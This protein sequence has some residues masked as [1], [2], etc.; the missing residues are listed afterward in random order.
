MAYREQMKNFL[1]LLGPC[2]LTVNSFAGS[3]C[4]RHFGGCIGARRLFQACLVS[5]SGRPC[6]D[7]GIES[8]EER[9]SA[10]R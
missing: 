4:T 9:R 6:E 8:C 10:K 3:R 1:P 2:L 5:F 7:E